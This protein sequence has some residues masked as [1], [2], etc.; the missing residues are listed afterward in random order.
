MISFVQYLIL[1]E[2][3]PSEVETLARKHKSPLKFGLALT[4]LQ[5][6]KGTDLGGEMDVEG[7]AGHREALKKWYEIHKSK[8][9][10]K[11]NG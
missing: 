7:A 5:K 11:E 2:D 9:K 6:K 3:V 10:D 8:N 1:S 4:K